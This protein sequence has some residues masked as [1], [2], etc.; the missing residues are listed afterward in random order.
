M[1]EMRV[2]RS[3]NKNTTRTKQKQK[4]IK[5]N[6]KWRYVATKYR[7]QFELFFAAADADFNIWR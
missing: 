7:V 5:N 4:K 1:S 2:E 6:M 3:E